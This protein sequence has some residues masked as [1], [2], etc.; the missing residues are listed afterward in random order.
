MA[1]PLRV[2]RDFVAG[3]REAEVSSAPDGRVYFA[4]QYSFPKATPTAFKVSGSAS[5]FYDLEAVVYFIKLHA[6]RGVVGEYVGLCAKENV[7]Q[8]IFVDRKVGVVQIMFV[9][10]V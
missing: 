9:I 1:D 6:K 2:L 8:V 3:G 4:D 7:R 10:A 5:D